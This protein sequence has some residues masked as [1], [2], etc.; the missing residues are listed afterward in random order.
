MI[1]IL[2]SNRAT[3]G[4]NNY[5]FFDSDENI[6]HTKALTP[7]RANDYL[8]HLEAEAICPAKYLFLKLCDYKKVENMRD[9]TI[10]LPF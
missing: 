2:K 5:T 4:E 9:F 6:A 8:I 1:Y 10:P 3:Q 7:E